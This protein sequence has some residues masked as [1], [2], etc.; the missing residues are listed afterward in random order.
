MGAGGVWLI[1]NQRNVAAI[2]YGGDFDEIDDPG[3]PRR[4]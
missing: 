1:D 3:A 4:A 2:R